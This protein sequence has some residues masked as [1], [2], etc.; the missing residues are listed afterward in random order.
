M[1]EGSPVLFG[2]GSMHSGKSSGLGVKA[3]TSTV[4]FAINPLGKVGQPLS[5][6]S[7]QLQGWSDED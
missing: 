4:D 6:P 1:Q 5:C 7:S 2:K 3:L